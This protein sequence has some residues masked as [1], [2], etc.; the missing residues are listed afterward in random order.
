[1]SSGKQATHKNPKEYA[2]S[3]VEWDAGVSRH[4]GGW[5]DHQNTQV[6]ALLWISVWSPISII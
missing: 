4:Y 1:M 6:G 2:E 5:H 3:G